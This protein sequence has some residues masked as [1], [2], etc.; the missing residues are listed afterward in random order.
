MNKILFLSVVFLAMLFVTSCS[1]FRGLV[2][3]DP[4]REPT[5]VAEE[6]LPPGTL[7][8]KLHRSNIDYDWINASTR[9]SIQHPDINTTVSS[10]IVL[11]KD[12]L[13]WGTVSATF[14]FEV[15]RF[16]IT[17]DS[18]R[19]IDRFNRAYYSLP[20][21]QIIPDMSE[22]NEDNFAVLQELI[23]GNYP[24]KNSSNLNSRIDSPNHTL[25]RERPNEKRTI[26]I[27]PDILKMASF[28][29]E[30]PEREEF[31]NIS[32]NNHG[33]EGGKKLFPK[34][35]AIE[36]TFGSDNKIEIDFREVKFEKK[37][38][39]NFDVPDNYERK[40]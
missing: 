9:M 24:F 28:Y 2:S 14:N 11:V 3:D 29:H 20:F 40:P 23:I 22:G 18:I 5:E 39:L 1:W 16:S 34:N 15:M 12:S 31:I 21:D 19:L 38:E 6:E 7:T 26:Q 17:P 27:F 8:D 37:D 36:N 13:I 25:Y 35:V 30:W 4:D 32:Y 10:N 33:K